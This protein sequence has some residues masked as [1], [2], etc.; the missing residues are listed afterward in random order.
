ML[1]ALELVARQVLAVFLVLPLVEHV[2]VGFPALAVV[3]LGLLDDFFAVERGELAIRQV[4]HLGGFVV[5]GEGDLGGGLGVVLLSGIGLV[6]DDRAAARC[7]LVFVVE[8]HVGAVEHDA[9][10]VQPFAAFRIVVFFGADG[11]DAGALAEE[12]VRH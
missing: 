1:D 4:H 7:Q 3:L 9:R 10:L 8:A 11:G 2:V 6:G 12:R 5:E